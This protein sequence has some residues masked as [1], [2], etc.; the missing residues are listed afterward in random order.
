M[1]FYSILWPVTLQDRYQGLSVDQQLLIKR[2]QKIGEVPLAEFS[3]ED[4]DDLKKL[5]S[6]EV[7]SLRLACYRW[8]SELLVVSGTSQK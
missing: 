2:V 4:I 7:L 3:K 8:G 1:I 6:S 5:I